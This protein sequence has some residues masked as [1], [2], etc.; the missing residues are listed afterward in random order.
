M[1]KVS[2]PAFSEVSRLSENDKAEL[3]HNTQK[4]YQLVWDETMRIAQELFENEWK[5]K[6]EVMVEHGADLTLSVSC[7]RG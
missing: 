4:N 7:L 6:K 3:P 2:A 1:R 5:G